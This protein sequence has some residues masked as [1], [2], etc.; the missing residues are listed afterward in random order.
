[1]FCFSDFDSVNNG[2]DIGFSLKQSRV[3]TPRSRKDLI[4][5]ANVYTLVTVR[6]HG[7]A[8]VIVHSK[9]LDSFSRNHSVISG[10]VKYICDADTNSSTQAVSFY[11]V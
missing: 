7:Q 4:T 6:K 5:R 2:R 8:E 10:F 9:H 1:M 11:Y 3:N